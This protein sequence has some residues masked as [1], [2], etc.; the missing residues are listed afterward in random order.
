MKQKRAKKRTLATT[1]MIF[2]SLNAQVTDDSG[3]TFL[4]TIPLVPLPAWPAFWWAL[5][6]TFNRFFRVMPWLARPGRQV[7]HWIR[8]Q[9]ASAWETTYLEVTMLVIGLKSSLYGLGVDL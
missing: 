5:A 7:G 6:A 1:A 8:A 9:V 2:L 4:T 3:Q